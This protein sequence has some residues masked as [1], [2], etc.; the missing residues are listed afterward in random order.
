M[1]KK[2][3]HKKNNIHMNVNN[4]Y[5]AIRDV[6][7]GVPLDLSAVIEWHELPKYN[8]IQVSQLIYYSPTMY[9]HRRKIVLLKNHGK[10]CKILP[11]RH[12]FEPKYSHT[13]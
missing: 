7:V 3:T 11:E 13:L 12:T 5:S 6:P 9:V 4:S 1:K 2:K 8:G 10:T